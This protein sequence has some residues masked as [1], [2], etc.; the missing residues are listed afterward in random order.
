MLDF[1]D[2]RVTFRVKKVDYYLLPLSFG[3]VPAVG[4]A[5]QVE[6][7]KGQADLL[8]LALSQKARCNIPSWRLRL[9]RK[10]SP[11]DAVRSLSV[12]QQAQLFGEWLGDMRGV[13]PGE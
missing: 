9:T 13:V 3:D 11:A 6:D 8:V 1:D 10:L 7:L 2:T 4:D 5:L 12:R